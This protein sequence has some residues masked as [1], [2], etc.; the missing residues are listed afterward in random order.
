MK[1]ELELCISEFKNFVLLSAQS[2]VEM[3]QIRSLSHGRK[4][5]NEDYFRNDDK[6]RFLLALLTGIF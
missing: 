4:A 5:F 2:E 6:V 3:L 1:V